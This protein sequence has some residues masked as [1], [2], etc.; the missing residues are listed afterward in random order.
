[1]MTAAAPATGPLRCETV[2][3]RLHWLPPAHEMHPPTREQQAPQHQHQRNALQLLHRLHHQKPPC[4]RMRARVRHGDQPEVASQPRP[5]APEHSCRIPTA[6]RAGSELAALLPRRP[7]LHLATSQPPARPRYHCCQRQRY[8]QLRV[9]E[10]HPMNEAQLAPQDHQWES[11]R[12]LP[13]LGH[14]SPHD[15]QL[16]PR[17][18]G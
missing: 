11:S 17:L 12:L 7:R 14:R 8:Q 2:C 13:S 16:Q 9:P 18:R 4:D 15:P 6:R 10:H 1:M 3:H 5:M